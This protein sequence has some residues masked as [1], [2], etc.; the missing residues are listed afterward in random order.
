MVVVGLVIQQVLDSVDEFAATGDH[1][2]DS[3]ARMVPQGKAHRISLAIVHRR[4]GLVHFVV[5][6]RGLPKQVDFIFRK[7]LADDNE[8]VPFVIGSFF[9][10]EDVH[11]FLFGVSQRRKGCTQKSMDRI[12]FL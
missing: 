11:G 12:R 5:R 2:V 3:V 10:G 6:S 9:G 1:P 8:S 4:G 7:E